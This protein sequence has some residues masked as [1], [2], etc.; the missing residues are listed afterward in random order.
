LKPFAIATSHTTGITFAT[1]AKGKFHGG[2]VRVV[3]NDAT[4]LDQHICCPVLGVPQLCAF[5]L[6]S[7]IM[8]P[9]VMP[10]NHPRENPIRLDQ[11]IDILMQYN[12]RHSDL[13]M[14]RLHAINVL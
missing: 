1:I 3:G 5:V 2:H 9:E 8:M 10:E 4:A 13:S 7:V 12:N 11:C 6:C 14:Y